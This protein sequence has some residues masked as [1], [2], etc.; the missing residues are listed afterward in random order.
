MPW[1]TKSSTETYETPPERVYTKKE[2]RENWWHYHWSWVALAIVGL[3]VVIALLRET[4][5]RPRPDLRVA[6]V[7]KTVMPE[8]VLSALEIELENLAQD[9]NGDG[10]VLV[11]VVPYVL[12]FTSVDAARAEADIAARARLAADL[13]MFSFYTVFL[14]DPENFQKEY[15][16]LTPLAENDAR[17]CYRWQEC[18]VLAGF[19]LGSYTANLDGETITLAG[20]S[21]VQD[22][23]IARRLPN[24][25]DGT[26]AAE[27]ALWQAL[28]AGAGGE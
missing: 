14:D 17:Y 27:L 23:F 5:F 3:I 11:E 2:K 19:D 7:T 16:V 25:E 21:A 8:E 13:G 10:R 18:P 12:D 24:P 15:E 4:V 6:C 9:G 22:L 26:P 28:T 1:V 20:E